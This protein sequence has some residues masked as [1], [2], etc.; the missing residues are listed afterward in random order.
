MKTCRRTYTFPKAVITAVEQEAERRILENRRR[1]GTR[2][3]GS[4]ARDI[5]CVSVKFNLNI[6]DIQKLSREEFDDLVERAK[7]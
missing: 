4:V 6:G 1:V 2:L 5:I 7:K 3:L